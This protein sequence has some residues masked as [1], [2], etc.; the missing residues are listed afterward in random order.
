M[1][2]NQ[3]NWAMFIIFGLYEV[4]QLNQHQYLSIIS[5]LPHPSN[6]VKMF[7]MATHRHQE[8]RHK[9]THHQP[10][11]LWQRTLH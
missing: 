6:A 4:Q 5:M 7:Q 11:R 8:N 2:L 10:T 3:E 9:V 1:L